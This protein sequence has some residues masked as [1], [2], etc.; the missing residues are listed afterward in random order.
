MLGSV[1]RLL[2]TAA[3]LAGIVGVCHA[4]SSGDRSKPYAN[5]GSDA[6]STG[7]GGGLDTGLTDGPPAPDAQG[8]C[9]NLVIPVITERPNVYFVVDRSGSM[10]EPL[11]K[12]SYNKYVNARIAIGKLLR[13]IGH[14]LRYGAAVFPM[15]GGTLQGCNPGEQIFPTQ[16]GD[17]ASYAAEGL[18]GPVLKKLLTVLGAYDP[19]GGTP[20]SGTLELL[21]PTLTALPGKTFVVL[22][23]DG[24]PN[25]NPNASCSADECMANIEGAYLDPTTPCAAPINCCDPQLVSNGPE[26]CVDRQATVN[27]VQKLHDAGILT[28]VIGMPGAEPYT[29]VLNEVATVG[30]TAKPIEPYYY[31]VQDEEEL[32]SALKEIGIKVAITCTIDLGSAP[33]DKNLVNVYLDTSLVQL[34]P[35]DGWSWTGDTTVELY[36]AACDKLKSG[37]VLQVQVVAGCPTSVK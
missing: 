5:G 27:V 21:V 6:G 17:P 18:S 36:G 7:G 29:K 23:T 35:V 15:P 4:C 25:C 12:S 24:A 37:D 26:L 30:G 31:P 33:P 28:Y 8:L 11:P 10:S 16:D 19:N 2:S 34:D 1:R 20:T 13:A 32:T 22:A 3:L 14:R 9:G